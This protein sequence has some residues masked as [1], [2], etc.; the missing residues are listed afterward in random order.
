MLLDDGVITRESAV[1]GA[2][3]Q[4]LLHQDRLDAARIP[5]TLVGV[6]VRRRF[7]F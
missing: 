7:G 3:E 2:S 5:G 6:R 4:W 1:P